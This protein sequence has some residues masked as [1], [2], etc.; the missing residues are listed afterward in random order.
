MIAAGAP[1]PCDCCD[2]APAIHRFTAGQCSDDLCDACARCECGALR[3][4][5]GDQLCRDCAEEQEKIRS[6]YA[7]T[8]SRLCAWAS[9]GF[10]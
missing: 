10:R 6:D 8:E 2:S 5:D 4:D 7:E 3:P 9:G 1:T